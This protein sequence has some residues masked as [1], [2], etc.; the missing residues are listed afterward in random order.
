MAIRPDKCTISIHVVRGWSY[1]VT[2][3]HIFVSYKHQVIWVSK[4]TR[5][6]VFAVAK[7]VCKD[8]V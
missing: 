4:Q 1:F 8:V 3:V 2:L 6:E 5:E 7:S